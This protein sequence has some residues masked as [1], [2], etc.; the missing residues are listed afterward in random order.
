MTDV[1]DKVG[2]YLFG[3]ALGGQ[4]LQRH[5]HAA[6][7]RGGLLHWGD[8]GQNRQ[9]G[10]LAPLKLKAEFLAF[11][12]AGFHG[13][14]EY[15]VGE[16]VIDRLADGVHLQQLVGGKVGPDHLVLLV[17]LQN[18]KRQRIEDMQVLLK[19]RAQAL[20]FV[21]KFLDHR[22]SSSRVAH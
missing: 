9:R 1:G 20:G 18:R 19:V 5:D 21:R 11:G 13:V 22:P 7:L 6:T 17:D 14:I 16:Y 8:R 2:A 12:E 4:V 3:L 15:V 10:P